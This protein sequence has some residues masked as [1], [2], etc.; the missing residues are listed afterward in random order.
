M[1]YARW[2]A[3]RRA[4]S[5]W[6]ALGLAVGLS[7]TV[8]AS[9]VFRGDQ[10]IWHAGATGTMPPDRVGR[11]PGNIHLFLPACSSNTCLR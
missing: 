5:R 4:G 11:G 1:V 7:L 8:A 2:I 10:G 6:L 3:S 9:A